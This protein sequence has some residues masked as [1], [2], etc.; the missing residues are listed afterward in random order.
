MFLG[1]WP[2]YKG[3]NK[4]SEGPLGKP[5][6]ASDAVGAFGEEGASMAAADT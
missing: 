4:R 6:G 2:G 5:Y 1:E 3:S